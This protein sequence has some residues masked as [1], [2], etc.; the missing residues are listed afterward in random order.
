MHPS[1][2]RLIVAAALAVVSVVALTGCIEFGEVAAKTDK[3]NNQVKDLPGVTASSVETTEKSA[4]SG[5]R[6]AVYL[7]VAE[8]ITADQVG[9][10][11]TTFAHANRE[12]GTDK[13]ST[14]LHL[15]RET[16]TMRNELQVQYAPL[17]DATATALGDTWVDLLGSTDGA[18]ITVAYA[19][20]GYDVDLNVDLP[21]DPTIQRDLD[22]LANAG[23]YFDKLGPIHSYN[24]ADGRFSAT[25]GIPGPDAITQL[26]YLQA[27]A[28]AV[29]GDIT[30]AYYGPSEL[31]S[32]KV[33]V[34]VAASTVDP[35]NGLPTSLETVVDAVPAGA[36]PVVFT[37]NDENPSIDGVTGIE[38]TNAKCDGYATLVSLEPSRTLLLYWARDG[39]TLINGSTVESCFS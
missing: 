29:G 7:D 33:T 12:T 10:I 20:S 30:G 4:F 19:S 36:F 16:A 21:G 14:E 5:R 28:V 22:A 35:A 37:V 1:P 2:R 27:A 15:L 34:P 9:T 31:N 17:T 24:E 11:I 3:V 26:A 25:G 18:S 13:V 8:G 32:L 39:R 6:S 23:T 38:F